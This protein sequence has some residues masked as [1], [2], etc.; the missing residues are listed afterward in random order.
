MTNEDLAKE[1][2]RGLIETGVEGGYDAVSCSSAGDYPSIG[3]SQWEGGRAD[4]LLSYIEGGDYFAGRSYSDI[5]ESG[6]L[7]YLADLISSEQGVEAQLAILADDALAYVDACI[8][9]GM[10]DSRCIIYAG[11]WG[12][13]STQVLYRFI[14][15]RFVEGHDMDNLKECAAVFRARYWIS[16]DVGEEYQEGYQNRSDNQYEY[17]KSLDLGAYGVSEYGEE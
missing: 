3:C 17:V 14:Y 2:A 15:N 9:A 10:N 1:I 12:P 7:D 5:K 4:M 6:E 8:D 16:A 11:M 13:T